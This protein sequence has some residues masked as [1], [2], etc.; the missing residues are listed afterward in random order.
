[1]GKCL[2][3]KLTLNLAKPEM[4]PL[5]NHTPK[6]GTCSLPNCMLPSSC[7]WIHWGCHW[8]LTLT[9]NLNLS[10]VLGVQG[11]KGFSSLV[12][13]I[14]YLREWPASASDISFS[15]FSSDWIA[16]DF[17]V[18]SCHYSWYV[19]ASSLDL[20]IKFWSLQNPKSYKTLLNL[21]LVEDR[22]WRRAP[23]AKLRNMRFTLI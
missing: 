5:K 22:V 1:M 9:P 13:W 7:S 3:W 18:S 14:K 19:S 12:H 20:S 6:F 21:L 11:S 8:M 23:D 15:S 2:A 10:V 17:F 4:I 16:R